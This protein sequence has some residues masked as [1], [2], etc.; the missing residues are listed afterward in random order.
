MRNDQ[1]LQVNM[2]LP[3]LFAAEN[4]TLEQQPFKDTQK[5]LRREID[6]L[7]LDYDRRIC[8]LV[9]CRSGSMELSDKVRT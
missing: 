2:G 8:V 7:F 3:G 9:E 6:G 1:R 4:L 5:P